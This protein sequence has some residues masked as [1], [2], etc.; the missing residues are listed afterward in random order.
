MSYFKNHL[1]K[2]SLNMHEALNVA[3][4]LIP[5]FPPPKHTQIR[6][7]S[8]FTLPSI[9]Q[10]KANLQELLLNINHLKYSLNISSHRTKDV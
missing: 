10:Q 5:A 2:H 8:T 9:I 7:I 3:F 1:L 6:F 4:Q